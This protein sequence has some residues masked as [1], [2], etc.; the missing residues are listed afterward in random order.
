[1]DQSELRW[2]GKGVGWLS[3]GVCPFHGCSVWGQLCFRHWLINQQKHKQCEP[4]LAPS[5]QQE[6][7]AFLQLKRLLA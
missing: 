3:P 4:H 5:R 2:T 7:R 6:Q 1:M